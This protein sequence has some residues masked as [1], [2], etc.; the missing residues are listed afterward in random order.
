MHELNPDS[1]HLFPLS[2]PHLHRERVGLT[3]VGFTND[4]LAAGANYV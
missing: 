2:Q 1:L 4:A 3:R